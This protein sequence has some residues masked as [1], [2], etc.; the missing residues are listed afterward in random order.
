MGDASAAVGDNPLAGCG[1]GAFVHV[2]NANA[3]A[4]RREP[5][6]DGLANSAA[7]AGDHGH[8]A[9]EPETLRVRC[10]AR[11]SETPRFQGMKSSCAFISALVRTSP[12]AT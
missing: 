11:Q 9:V 4:M 12:L 6:R 7:G 5:Q 1:R 3:R 2:Q 8:F 10:L